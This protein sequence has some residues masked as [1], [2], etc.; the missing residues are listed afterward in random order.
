MGHGRSMTCYGAGEADG[1]GGK[2]YEEALLSVVFLS[3]GN[4]RKC[5]IPIKGRAGEKP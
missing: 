4:M 5:R 1:T 2:A 3:A